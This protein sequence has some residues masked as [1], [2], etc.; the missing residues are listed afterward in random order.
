MSKWTPKTTQTSYLGG[1]RIG[2]NPSPALSHRAQTDFLLPVRVQNSY[3]DFLPDVVFFCSNEPEIV[4][5]IQN[6]EF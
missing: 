3:C 5:P 2:G 1:R 6:T 4:K